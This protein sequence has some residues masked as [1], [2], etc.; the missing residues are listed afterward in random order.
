MARRCLLACVKTLQMFL[1]ALTLLL[2]LQSCQPGSVA[3]ASIYLPTNAVTV[4]GLLSLVTSVECDNVVLEDPRLC[5]TGLSRFHQSSFTVTPTCCLDDDDDSSSFYIS[6]SCYTN[7]KPATRTIIF[8]HQYTSRR[9]VLTSALTTR[10]RFHVSS[11]N[12]AKNNPNV[13]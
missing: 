6:H 2:R 5:V 9:F 7:T 8:T 11:S 4:V 12:N 3:C 10:G 1:R 13:S